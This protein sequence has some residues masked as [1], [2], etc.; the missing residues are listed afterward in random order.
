VSGQS[1]FIDFADELVPFKIA[2]R[3]IAAHAD[4]VRHLPLGQK[5]A[6][7]VGDALPNQHEA[8]DC[9]EN[10]LGFEQFG[11]PVRREGL[12]GSA[13]HDKTTSRRL[14]ADEVVPRCGDC[15]RLMRLGVSRLWSCTLALQ[16]SDNQS[17]I[18]RLPT[19]ETNLDRVSHQ[20]AL[21]DRFRAGMRND[22][23]GDIAA[24]VERKRGE[25]A[26][27]SPSEGLVALDPELN[28]DSPVLSVSR[29]GYQVNAF[30]GMRKCKPFT[31]RGGHVAQRPDVPKD[32]SVFRL[33]LE[34][35]LNEPFERATHLGLGELP[36]PLPEIVP[37]G[38]GGNKA[39]HAVHD[40]SAVRPNLICYRMANSSPRV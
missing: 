22:R 6:G 27:F 26:Q 40:I 25:G 4:P 11:Y 16:P 28:L 31:D 39:V 35:E 13:R 12:A 5:L 38:A 24:R 23:Q 15:S 21:A 17:P 14:V 20:V 10:S 37:R 1:K 2:N 8:G 32:G 19:V 29:T 3:L 34:V 18:Q 30:V 7:P 33:G 9:D 36:R